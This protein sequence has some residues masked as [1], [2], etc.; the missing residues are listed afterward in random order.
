MFKRVV[1]HRVLFRSAVAA[2][3][4]L[5]AAAAVL[6]LPGRFSA[7][8]R[9]GNAAAAGA[10]APQPRA[11][12]VTLTDS[13]LR[14][15]KVAPAALHEF[16][17]LREAV[18]YIDFNQDRTVPVLSPWAGRIRRVFVQAGDEVRQGEALFT[19]DSPDL[20]QA[21]STLIATAGAL[22]LTTKALERAKKMIETQA[23]S[24]KDL[25]QATSDQQS[26]EANYKAA[27]QAVRIFGKSEAQL[28]AIIASRKTDGELEVASP[29]A[30][31]VTARNA[32][33]GV[34]VQPGGT[35]APITVADLSM[36]WMV[37]SVTEY[38][39]PLLR[40]GQQVSVSMPAFPGRKFEARITNI[41]ATFDP[42]THRI[43]VR[44]EI[45]DPHHEL[46]PQMLATF[47]IRTGEPTR[48]VALPQG[49]VVREGDGTM[50]AFVT[51]DGHRFERRAVQ[52]GIEQEGMTQI[53][54]GLDPGELAASDGALFLSNAL[55]LQTR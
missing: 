39:L 15:V 46:R 6:L 8:D 29:I 55:A 4:L 22:E 7:D 53:L 40:L 34:L 16:A 54:G 51:S 38:D 36:L 28:G 41:A 43:A 49:G 20:V 9:H 18:G 14:L 30:G 26:A 45:Q 48:S 44:S 5:L 19:V 24:Q 47:L 27:R 32:S 11:T 2:V 35:P 17:S 42:A 52:L 10:S 33:P 23:S 12:G 13:Q 50:V 3:A 37:A 1:S 21:E 31:R 25:D